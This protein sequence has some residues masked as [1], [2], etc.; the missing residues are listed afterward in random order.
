M[1]WRWY[2]YATWQSLAILLVSLECLDYSTSFGIGLGEIFQAHPNPTSGVIQGSL[3][4]DGTYIMQA[5][6]VLVTVKM[7]IS[8]T[9]H[10]F[11]SIFFQVAC[12]VFFYAYVLVFSFVPSPFGLSEMLGVGTPLLGHL[13]NYLLLFITVV[14]FSFIDVGMW[15]IDQQVQLAYDQLEEN[16]EE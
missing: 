16:A 4:L 5:I 7:F 11:W 10:T 6:V 14:A 3:W 1:F 13:T 8:T 15:H 9:S 2:F 12:L